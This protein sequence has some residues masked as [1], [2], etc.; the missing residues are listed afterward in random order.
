MKLYEELDQEFNL[1]SIVDK[2][3]VIAKIKEFDCDKEKMNEWVFEK[4]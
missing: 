4:L 2:A 3:E 1:S